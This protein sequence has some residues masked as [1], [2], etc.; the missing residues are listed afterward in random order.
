MPNALVQGNPQPVLA[1]QVKTSSESEKANRLSEAPEREPSAPVAE[2]KPESTTEGVPQLIEALKSPAI[3]ER[4]R[5]AAA[6]HS[7]GAQAKE[8]IPALREALKDQDKDVQMWA[9]LALV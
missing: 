3:A 6:L 2:Q 7:L 8:A 1:R 9:A 5:A 4:Q